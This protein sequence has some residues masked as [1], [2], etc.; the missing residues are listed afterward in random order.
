MELYRWV[1]LREDQ[2]QEGYQIWGD[3]GQGEDC[4]QDV[5]VQT[6][7]WILK[8]CSGGVNT[9]IAFVIKYTGYVLYLKLNPIYCVLG[10]KK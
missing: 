1:T 8:L 5:E 9:R 4:Q 2:E 6:Y 7:L 10:L 3:H